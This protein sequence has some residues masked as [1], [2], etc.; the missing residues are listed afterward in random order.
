[1]DT[2]QY[3][4]H[5]IV[6]L[7]L[8]QLQWG[9]GKGW[10]NW[11]YRGKA[12]V[13]CRGPEAMTLSLSL[14]VLPLR[15]CICKAVALDTKLIARPILCQDFHRVSFS[16]V[17]SLCIRIKC[18]AYGQYIYMYEREV[19]FFLFPT[20]YWYFFIF[21]LSLFPRSVAFDVGFCHWK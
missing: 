7:Y 6:Y 20:L 12:S 17:S 19:V 8:E 14:C 9:G 4:L 5:T 2:G 10:Q 3:R 18:K 21:F 16:L 13:I 11:L 15:V 1:M